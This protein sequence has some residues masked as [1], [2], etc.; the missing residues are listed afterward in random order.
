MVTLSKLKSGLAWEFGSKLNSPQIA[1]SEVRIYNPV[2]GRSL[3]TTEA[4]N[5]KLR[6]S[7]RNNATDDRPITEEKEGGE[8]FTEK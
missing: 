5:M 4:Y 7:P 1:S 8:E 3:F 2:I 6:G